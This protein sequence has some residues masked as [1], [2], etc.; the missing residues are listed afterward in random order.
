MRM[1]KGVWILVLMFW[2]VGCVPLSID[3]EFIQEHAEIGLS[4]E[5]VVQIFGEPD[6]KG[7]D[8]NVEVWVF[9]KTKKGYEN[10]GDV[11][12][13]NHQA[14]REGYIKWSFMVYFIENKAI[15]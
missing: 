12:R 6:L 13:L 4:K 3:K 1:K 8:A 7:M 11:Q 5:Q 2:L 9:E 15:G 14:I 10:D